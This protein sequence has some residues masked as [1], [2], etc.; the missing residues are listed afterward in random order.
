MTTFTTSVQWYPVFALPLL[1][2]TVAVAIAADRFFS[3]R[4]VKQIKMHRTPVPLEDIESHISKPISSTSRLTSAI[5]AYR[6]KAR[7]NMSIHEVM[8]EDSQ[9]IAGEDMPGDLESDRAERSWTKT[10]APVPGAPYSSPLPKSASAVSLPSFRSVENLQD[11]PISVPPAM[12]TA[13][14]AAVEVIQSSSPQPPRSPV[15]LHDQHNS[16][17]RDSS[18]L[19]RSDSAHESVQVVN[20]RNVA[21]D[22][23]EPAIKRASGAM[24][25]PTTQTPRTVKPP[26][27]QRPLQRPALSYAEKIAEAAAYQAEVTAPPEVPL[28]EKALE[29]HKKKAN[30]TSSSSASRYKDGSSHAFSSYSRGESEKGHIPSAFPRARQPRDSDFKYTIV[31]RDKE[32]NEVIHVVGPG[33]SSRNKTYVRNSSAKTSTISQ[34]KDDTIEVK[35]S[36]VAST[37]PR[38][39]MSNTAMPYAEQSSHLSNADDGAQ[40]GSNHELKV[41]PKIDKGKGIEVN[42]SSIQTD[43]VEDFWG[44]AVSKKKN[45]KKGKKKEDEAPP[46][47]SAGENS[48]AFHEI[49][50]D[51]TGSM[52]NSDFNT[53]ISTES[54][55]SFGA[56]GSFE[57]NNETTRS[58]F[59]FLRGTGVFG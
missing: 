58:V 53:G 31:Q 8:P 13:R 33:D 55:S 36:S 38:S 30:A 25:P 11:I 46:T 35:L 10:Q 26:I 23:P 20:E 32:S 43:H 24:P 47:L 14:D 22:L 42:A 29:K 2:I 37:I 56:W 34:R 44:F 6:R 12:T 27:I 3:Q 40:E 39:A 21:F 54:T 49:K 1:A 19:R 16:W 9:S 41:K 50:P 48:D 5:K 7:G 15:S 45:R 4:Q 17:Q 51:D 59:F 28:T 52:L 57:S 18:D